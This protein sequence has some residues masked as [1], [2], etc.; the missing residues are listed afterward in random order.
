MTGAHTTHYTNGTVFQVDVG[1]EE[2]EREKNQDERKVCDEDITIEEVYGRFKIRKKVLLPSIIYE[3]KK[4]DDLLRWCLN[5]DLAWVLT[6]AV[7]Q[8][9]SYAEKLEPLE[10]WSVY[11]KQVTW[12]E[13]RKAVLEYLPV[14]AL[15]PSDNI[16]RWYLDK[17]TE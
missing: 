6:S 16:C 1:T 4:D 10:S 15:P 7:G 5:R 17:M 9:L 11:M 3:D 13:T 14:V 2:T 8:Q 12:H